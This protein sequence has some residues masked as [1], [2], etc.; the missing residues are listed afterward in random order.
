VP[1]TGILGI[2]AIEKRPRVLTGPEGED[3]IAIRTCS[4]FSLSFDHRV[5]DGADGDRFLASVKHRLE[6]LPDPAF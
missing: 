2:G 5:V 3:V 1:T 4:Y 6:N